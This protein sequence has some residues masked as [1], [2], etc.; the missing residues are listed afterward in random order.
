MG[1]K[2]AVLEAALKL[3]A[4]DRAELAEVLIGSL[5]DTDADVESAWVGEV[6][7]RMTEEAD[8]K[9]FLKPGDI[10]AEVKKILGR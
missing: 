4:E 3:P 10:E 9:A 8:R 6:K 7:R 1:T 5:D 2:H